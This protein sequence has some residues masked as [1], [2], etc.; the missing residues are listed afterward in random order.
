MKNYSKKIDI[1]DRTLKFG[2][3]IVILAN[4][5]PNSP[6]GFKIGGQIVASGTSIGAN[7]QE[8][9]SASSKKDFIY[10]MGIAL[11]EA[12]ETKYWLM[13]IVSAKLLPMKVIERHLNENEEIIKILCTIIKNTKSHS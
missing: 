11:R 6:A 2:V 4:K 9:Q 7:I 13:I 12:R 8:A 10:K 1:T 3:E 5:L